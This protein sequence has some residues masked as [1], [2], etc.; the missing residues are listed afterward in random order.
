MAVQAGD[1]RK[2]GLT[3]KSLS[4]IKKKKCEKCKS[5]LEKEL[6]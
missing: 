4:T 3:K 2:K 1:T 5:G 6:V